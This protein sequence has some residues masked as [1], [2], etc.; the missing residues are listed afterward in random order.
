M[1]GIY[2]Y[3]IEGKKGHTRRAFADFQPEPDWILAQ[4][5]SSDS[6]VLMPELSYKHY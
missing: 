6:H 4:Q 1:F 3:K 5:N 2:M